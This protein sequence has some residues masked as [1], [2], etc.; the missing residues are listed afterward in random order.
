MKSRFK[1]KPGD[2]VVWNIEDTQTGE[3]SRVHFLVLRQIKKGTRKM[4]KFYHLQKKTTFTHYIESIEHP[5]LSN[6]YIE[7]FTIS[8]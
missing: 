6:I 2:I 3:K 1:Y 5:V 8:G 7:V 4:Y